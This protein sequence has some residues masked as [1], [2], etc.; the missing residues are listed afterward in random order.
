MLSQLHQKWR[1]SFGFQNLR[2]KNAMRFFHAFFKCMHL[3]NALHFFNA[4][5]NAD[6]K[7][8]SREPRNCP[9]VV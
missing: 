5:K 8:A 7:G 3:K 2:K 6:F 1:H 9:N 4:E